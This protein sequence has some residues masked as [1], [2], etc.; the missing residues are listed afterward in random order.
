MPIRGNE[1]VVLLVDRSFVKGSKD[2]VKKSKCALGPN[3][4]AADVATR[5]ELEKVEATDV[6]HFNSR[7]IAECFDNAAVFVVDNEGAATLAVTA[8]AH[9]SLTGAKLARV[10]H[11]YDVAI[12]TEGLEKSNGLLCFA[13]GLDSITNNK[14]NFLYLLDAVATSEN[15]RGKCGRSEGRDSSK[16]A[17]IL[18]HLDMPSTPGLRGRKHPTTT[19]HVTERGLARTVSASSANT[20]NTRDGTTS[21]P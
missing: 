10:G 11:L 15:E 21:T 6:N 19:T 5:C 13:E 14:G 17:L 20:G 12:R 7:Q 16:A 9:L 18:V 4:K 2:L 8:I 3:N 1:Q